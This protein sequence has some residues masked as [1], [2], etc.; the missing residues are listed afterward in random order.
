MWPSFSPRNPGETYTE[1]VTPGQH[2][3]V[4]MYQRGPLRLAVDRDHTLVTAIW[5]HGL[6]GG[7]PRSEIEAASMN[8]IAQK[9]RPPM[10]WTQPTPVSDVD[11]AFP[12]LGVQLTPTDD[13][14]ADFRPG[15]WGDLAAAALAY[16]DQVQD[17]ALAPRDGIDPEAAWRHLSVVLGCYGTKNQVKARGAAWLLSLWFE[18]AIWNTE[19]GECE[20][21][22]H[23]TVLELRDLDR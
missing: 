5:D 21:G 4:T 10:D 18:A 22:D 13:V 7:D 14:P 16:G 20:A 8:A 19:N 11:I 15:A 2:F 17:L 23:D 6:T 1:S 9:E 12:A 3:P